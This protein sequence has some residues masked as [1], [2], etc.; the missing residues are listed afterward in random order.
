MKLLIDWMSIQIYNYYMLFKFWQIKRIV[1]VVISLLK[2]QFNQ[3]TTVFNLFSCFFYARWSVLFVAYNYL[4]PI[5]A[6]KLVFTIRFSFLDDLKVTRKLVFTIKIKIL[7]DLKGIIKFMIR[8][9]FY[10]T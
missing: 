8:F 1:K 10:M 2:L 4:M 9:G 7:S 6:R 3:K 5:L